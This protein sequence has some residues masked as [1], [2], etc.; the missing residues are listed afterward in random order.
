MCAHDFYTMKINLL[1]LTCLFFISCKSGSP[2]SFVIKE[3]INYR[4]DIGSIHSVLISEQDKNGNTIKTFHF[5]GDVKADGRREVLRTESIEA[6]FVNSE[7][8]V[9]WLGSASVEITEVD[10]SDSV[11][12]IRKIDFRE[13][14]K[15]VKS[16]KSE[17][18]RF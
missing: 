18:V 8:R 11:V 14:G 6:N 10:E 3:N 5:R 7:F 9:K 17:S 12:S 16:V 1:L 13:K 4:K 15:G 2:Y